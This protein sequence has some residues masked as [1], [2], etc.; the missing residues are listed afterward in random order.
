MLNHDRSVCSSPFDEHLASFT[1]CGLDG[2]KRLPNFSYLLCQKMIAHI[3]LSR[4]DDILI[5]TSTGAVDSGDYHVL[6]SSSFHSPYYGVARMKLI[7]EHS[8]LFN[9]AKCSDE[10]LSILVS[11]ILN[12]ALG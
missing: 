7:L 9:N 3:D 8:S 1:I 4:D 10:S 6:T 11:K 12:I 5:E 2:I